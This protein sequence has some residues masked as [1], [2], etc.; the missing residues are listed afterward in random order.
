[1]RCAGTALHRSKGLAVALPILLSGFIRPEPDAAFFRLRRHCS[2]L[3]D[4]SRRALPATRLPEVNRGDVRTFLP[5]PLSQNIKY[6]FFTRVLSLF[7]TIPRITCSVKVV[8][9]NYP[10]QRLQD[11]TI[12]KLHNQYIFIPFYI[13]FV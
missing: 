8:G 12:E 7:M 10:T 9:G 13:R 11:Y 5:P 4:C 2:H 6:N 1:M 3:V